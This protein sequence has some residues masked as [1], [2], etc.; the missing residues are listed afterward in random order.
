MINQLILFNCCADTAFVIPKLNTSFIANNKPTNKPDIEL[1]NIYYINLFYFFIE[2]NYKLIYMEVKIIHS[3]KK[4]DRD[5]INNN[6]SLKLSFESIYNK[7][8]P[9]MIK[10]FGKIRIRLPNL[11]E[12]YKSQLELIDGKYFSK[13]PIDYTFNDIIEKQKNDRNYNISLL[14]LNNEI[15]AT[16]TGSLWPDCYY[17]S[18]VRSN[19]KGGCTSVISKLLDSWWDNKNLKF[20]SFNSINDPPVKLHV[21]PDNLPAIGCYKKFG[22]VMTEE[23][24]KGEYLMI[25][26]KESYAKNYL[27]PLLENKLKNKIISIK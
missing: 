12:K 3:N 17:I 18:L 5:F 11:I 9:E 4:E 8:I 24:L 22:F 7:W 23:S 14:I 26:T 10:Q 6:Q 1:F 16:A 21:L 20:S 2:I 13:L 25:L 19:Y 27:I 15:V